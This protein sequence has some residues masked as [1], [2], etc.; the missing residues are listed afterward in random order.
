M[1]HGQKTTDCI[2]LVSVSVACFC[3]NDFRTVRWW[4]EIN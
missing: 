4:E 3:G 2:G 1:I